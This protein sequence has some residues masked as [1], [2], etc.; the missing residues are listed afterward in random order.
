MKSLCLKAQTNL[1]EHNLKDKGKKT[2]VCRNG[3]LKLSLQHIFIH[4]NVFT[5]YTLYL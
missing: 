4:G 1:V 2:I 3:G 5:V